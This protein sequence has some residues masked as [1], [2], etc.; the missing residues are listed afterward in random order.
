MVARVG[1]S[2]AELPLLHPCVMQVSWSLICIQTITTEQAT[3]CFVKSVKGLC[4]WIWDFWMSHPPPKR[5]DWSF[6]ILIMCIFPKGVW[7]LGS[8]CVKD[9]SQLNKI[10]LCHQCSYSQQWRS[11]NLLYC[12]FSTHPS[13]FVRVYPVRRSY[14]HWAS[15]IQI[16]GLCAVPSVFPFN[17]RNIKTT[18]QS[19]SQ[20]II[21][22]LLR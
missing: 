21:H 22:E 9:F 6:V 4:L 14:T 11:S 2:A 13:H 20:A 19:Q 1:G 5:S 17:E 3:H 8:L 16:C 18:F 10:P 12:L 15:F 7:F